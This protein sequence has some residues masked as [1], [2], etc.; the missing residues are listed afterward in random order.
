MSC[1]PTP[2]LTPSAT[3]PLGFRRALTPSPPTRRKTTGLGLPRRWQIG[4]TNTPRASTCSTTSP[5]RLNSA[6]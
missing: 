4:G 6:G 5:R 1:S 2:T 3:L